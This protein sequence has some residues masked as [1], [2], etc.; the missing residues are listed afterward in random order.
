MNA[1]AMDA[2]LYDELRVVIDFQNM[3]LANA[4][5]PRTLAFLDND[6]FLVEICANPNIVGVITQ[7]RHA[8]TFA[9]RRPDI[10]LYITDEPRYAFYAA[11]NANASRNNG[12]LGPS[13]IHEKAKVHDRAYVAPT[14]VHIDAYVVIEPRVTVMP[15]VKIGSRSIIRAGSSIGVE[16]FEHKRVGDRLLSVIHDRYVV[17]GEDVEIGANNTIARGLMGEDTEIGDETKTDCLVH[18]AHC[19]KIGRRCLIPA[20]A[21]IAGSVTIGDDVWIGPGALVSNSIV[22]GDKASITIGA[23][24]VKNVDPEQ[25]VTG[26]FA[27]PHRTFLKH[28]TTILKSRT[29]E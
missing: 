21:M 28:L 4:R 7:S 22:I 10:K 29:L 23:V 9:Q 20:A 6:K 19:A 24:V 13:Q 5:I 8:A 17:I 15:G 16:G 14:G 25:R 3:G 26:N 27:I 18:I 11:F 2:A 12:Q 1:T